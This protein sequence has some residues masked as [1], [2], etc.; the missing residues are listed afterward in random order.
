MKR[1]KII[2]GFCI[3]FATIILA[4]NTVNADIL[5]DI[6]GSVTNMIVGSP[7]EDPINNPEAFQPG[8]MSGADEV[9][10]IGN[11]IIG[12][13]RFV[14][15]FA[16]VIVLIII[17]IK[18]MTGSLEERAEYKKTMLPYLIGAILVFAIT[19]IL[20]IVDTITGGLF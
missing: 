15:S 1:K 4:C 16:S 19:N 12:V 14:G 10:D 18:Y 13:I 20:G 17:G 7:I 8:S 6:T 2:C 5:G 3:F 11:R 9:M